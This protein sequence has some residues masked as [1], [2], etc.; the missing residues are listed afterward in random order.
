MQ[1]GSDPQGVGLDKE[2]YFSSL[3]RPELVESQT[4][5][6]LL[7]SDDFARCVRDSYLESQH[8]EIPY[9][10]SMGIS[11]QRIRERR[12]SYGIPL[13]PLGC[14]CTKYEYRQ[15]DGWCVVGKGARVI[16]RLGPIDMC[17][18]IFGT[19]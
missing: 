3:T 7:G 2:P 13:T 4:K 8:L 12:E 16:V 14:V 18:Y 6:S 11:P 17:T 5:P 15:T 1:C 9:R 10:L 19:T